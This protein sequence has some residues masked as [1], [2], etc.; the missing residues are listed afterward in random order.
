MNYDMYANTKCVLAL[1]K[2]KDETFHVY[3]DAMHY[4]HDNSHKFT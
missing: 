3:F 2:S 1:A 4:I